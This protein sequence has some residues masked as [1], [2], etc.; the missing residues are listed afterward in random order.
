L[1]AEWVSTVASLATLVVVAIAAY[2]ALRQMRHMRSGNQVAALLPLAAEYRSTEI[3]ESLGYV[4]TQL[5]DDLK[6][7]N[8]R[9]GVMAIPTTGPA[10]SA[11]AIANFYETIG[12]LVC[13]GVLDLEL[14]LR[15]FTLPSELWAK[16]EDYIALTR[17]SRGPEVF[18][19]FEALVALE[20]RYAARNGTSLYP[21]GL[22]HV[23]ARER[24]L[25]RD[26]REVSV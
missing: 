20:Q 8:N 6:D 19:H 22:P 10:R 15:Y 3:S 7:P 14:I 16:A 18:E 25:Q 1:S 21:R 9:E 23:P 2:A 17:R 12:A 11:K 4:L 24:D 13:A 26:A 5:N